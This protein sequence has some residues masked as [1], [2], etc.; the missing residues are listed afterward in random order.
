MII[1]QV[2]ILLDG[3]IAN[4]NNNHHPAATNLKQILMKDWHCTELV[5]YSQTHE[6]FLLVTSI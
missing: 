2:D 4:N 6:G 3:G 5:G 1:Y